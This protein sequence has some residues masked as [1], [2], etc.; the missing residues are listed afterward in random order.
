MNI[1]F[2]GSIRG[3]REDAA[4]YASIIDFLRELGTVLTEHVGSLADVPEGEERLT[5]RQIHDRDMGWLVESDIMIAEVTVPSL[6]VGYEIGR[7]VELGKPV[8]CLFRPAAG[9]SL[10]AMIAG[11]ADLT[12]I[13]YDTINRL[14]VELTGHIKQTLQHF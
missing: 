4:L 8:L 2:G 12:V 10:S 14:K 13:R 3:G 7:A 11:C 5:N 6:G 1:Y 9:R